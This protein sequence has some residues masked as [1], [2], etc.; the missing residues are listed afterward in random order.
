MLWRM[1]E[2]GREERRV[3]CAMPAR[4]RKTGWKRVGMIGPRGLVFYFFIS[5]YIQI[6]R[7]K[8][9]K[10]REERERNFTYFSPNQRENE[11]EKNQLTLALALLNQFIR[12]RENAHAVREC[13]TERDGEACAYVS[14]KKINNNNINDEKN[15][16]KHLKKMK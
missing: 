11:K 6:P 10:G 16:T 5:I 9:K 15:T 14:V 1:H 3:V 2:G 4:S 12:E 7:T 8:T 13:K